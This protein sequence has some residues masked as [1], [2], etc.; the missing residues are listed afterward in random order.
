MATYN[1]FNALSE[2]LAEKKHD[3]GSDQLKVALTNTEP[4]ATDST[5]TDITEIDYTNCSSRDLTTNSS[6]QS[7][8]TYTLEVADLTLSA[9][10][11]TVGPFQYVVLY[12]DTASNDELIGYYDYGT[13]V[14]LNDGDSFEIDANQVEGILEISFA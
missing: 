8:G 11:G 10:G 4:S 12:N 1:K 6:S 13:E 9:S 7:S 5:L 3:L 2:A 14:T